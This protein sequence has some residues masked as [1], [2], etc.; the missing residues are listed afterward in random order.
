MFILKRHEC[1]IGVVKTS[2]MIQGSSGYQNNHYLYPYIL[3]TEMFSSPQENIR[4]IFQ[5]IFAHDIIMR[6]DSP[7][8]K[9]LDRDPCWYFY[10]GTGTGNTL[11]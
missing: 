3:K 8:F 5:N 10:N 4:H 2:K 1:R 9:V 6:G 11:W 7:Y